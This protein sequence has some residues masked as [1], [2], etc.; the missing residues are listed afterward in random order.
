MKL[1]AATSLLITLLAAVAA[2]PEPPVNQYLPPN[3]QFIPSQIPSDFVGSNP[4]HGP[5]GI[6][7][8]PPNSNTFGAHQGYD[9]GSN[10]EPA[11]YEFEYTVNDFES[12]N[13][14]GHRENTEGGVA[15]GI[16]YVL[17]PDGRRQTVEYEADENG[18]RPKVTYTDE[19]SRGGNTGGNGG[20][21]Y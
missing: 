3:Q 13:D 10:G 14:F 19:G 4:A 12:G 9:D 1:F 11:K 7:Y 15:R 21:G 17:L 16:Y 8:L 18:F 6:Q 5:G 2:R 20:Y